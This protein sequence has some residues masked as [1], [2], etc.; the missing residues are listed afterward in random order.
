MATEVN[1][2][3]IMLY[4]YDS[5]TGIS[6]PFGCMNNASLLVESSVREV[7]NEQ[8]AFYKEFKN[9]V[10]SWSISGS[11]FIILNDQYNYFYILTQIANRSAITVKFV[12][13]N[14]GTLGLSIFTGQVIITS[15]QIDGT[16]DSLATY[17]VTMQGT[18]EYSTSGTVITPGGT[19]II[20]GTTLQVFQATATGGET[21]ITFSGAVGLD[22]VYASRGGT[23]VQPLE[24]TGLPTAPNGGVWVTSTGVLDLSQAAFA[25]ELFLILAQ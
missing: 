4:Q 1:G 13:D 24:F 22:C 9:D 21:S 20:S 10:N 8:S 12:I 14:G 18:G 19:T 25:G 17:S 3:N 11:G 5:D 7:T 15:I 23:T 16:D 6:V 2:R